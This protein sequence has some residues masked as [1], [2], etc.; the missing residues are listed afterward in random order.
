MVLPLHVP[1][2]L[3]VSQHRDAKETLLIIS[4]KC[5]EL[6]TYKE[7]PKKD[8]HRDGHQQAC[9]QVHGVPRDDLTMNDTVLSEAKSSY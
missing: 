4:R 9:R 1:R 6:E 5:A 7:T 8:M 2:I 3:V